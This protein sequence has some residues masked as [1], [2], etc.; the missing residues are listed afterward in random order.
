MAAL[1]AHHASARKIVLSVDQNL[2]SL[3]TGRDTS[4]QLQTE[5]SQQLNML[6]REVHA[7]EQELPTVGASERLVWKKRIA[8]LQEQSKSQRA[9]LTRFAG[10]AAA[11][12]RESEER[13]ALLQR[14]NGGGGEHA[15]M[16]DAMANESRRL[17]DADNQLDELQAHA[18]A[19]LNALVQ[20]R[21]SL[22]G[23]Q[24]KVLDMAQTLGLSNNVLRMIERRAF[25]DKIILYGGM[26]ATLALIWFVFKYMRA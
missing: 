7:L 19:S 10:R 20:Q 18:T 25:W 15:I 12:Q 11:Q 2:E 5:I 6:A 3:E 8:Q 17:H 23:V 14:R 21:S 4:L 13:D 22:K 24:R 1:S 16:I 26:L 9:A